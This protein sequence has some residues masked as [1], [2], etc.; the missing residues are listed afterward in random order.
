MNINNNVKK[1][2]K[3]FKQ[4]LIQEE[5]VNQLRKALKRAD[6]YLK[7]VGF[8][9]YINSE[10]NHYGVR[11]I[12]NLTTDDYERWIT[13]RMLKQFSKDRDWETLTF[14]CEPCTMSGGHSYLDLED[15][16]QIVK[17]WSK[18]IKVCEHLNELKLEGSH[19]AILYCIRDIKQRERKY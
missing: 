6:V 19:E 17:Y 13:I 15:A 3:E 9:L 12:K 4:S 18:L 8:T 10:L 7:E 1:P 5:V 16:K 2:V 14:V 11:R